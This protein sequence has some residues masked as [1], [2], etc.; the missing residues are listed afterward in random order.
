[1]SI[2]L[3]KFNKIQADILEHS[4]NLKNST[5]II[6]VSKTFPIDH[7]RPLID[8]GHIHFGEN[9]VQEA[10]KKWKTVKHKNKN[11]KLHMLGK[12]QTNKA[13]KAVSIFD[14]IHSV[15]SKKLADILKKSE[16]EN[17]KNL[18]YFIQV[19]FAD[20]KQKSGIQASDALPFYKYC[21][22]EIN[23]NVVGLM[24]FPPFDLDPTKF[25]KQAFELNNKLGLSELSMGMSNDYFKAIKFGSTFVRIGNAIFG[26]RKV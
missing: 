19:N 1:M 9:K 12:L 11:L 21:K 7:I 4:A 6:A 2:V 15:D 13:K 16:I 26:E 3:E 18:T 20:E 22:N 8:Q 25:F 5:K 23:L 17:G 14:Y 24:C 10:E